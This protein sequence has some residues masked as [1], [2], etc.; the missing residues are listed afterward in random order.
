MALRD[1]AQLGSAPA[2]GAGC[3]RFESCHPDLCEIKPHPQPPPRLRGGG[4]DLFCVSGYSPYRIFYFLLIREMPKT[5][6]DVA[7]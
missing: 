5:L 1:V 4:Y 2:L 6:E 3:R 7:S